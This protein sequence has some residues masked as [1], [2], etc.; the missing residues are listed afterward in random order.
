MQKKTRTNGDFRY[1]GMNLM[2]V[3]R[4]K[5]QKVRKEQE[6]QKKIEGLK[7]GKERRTTEKRSPEN[8]REKRKARR[9]QALD[10]LNAE[11]K[12]SRKLNLNLG[13]HEPGDTIPE[14]A[15][16]YCTTVLK[17]RVPSQLREGRVKRWGET[18]L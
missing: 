1:S 2:G 4:W 11:K 3:G 17:S 18:T 6:K 13:R 5:R 12:L 14:V 8:E 16:I 7:G 15:G 10:N 9:S